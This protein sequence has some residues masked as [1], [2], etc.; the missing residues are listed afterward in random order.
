MKRAVKVETPATQPFPK[1]VM[2]NAES[3]GTDKISDEQ[4]QEWL[5]T[6]D[7]KNFL[8]SLQ[9]GVK[10]PNIKET[11]QEDEYT[12][13]VVEDKESDSSFWSIMILIVACGLCIFLSSLG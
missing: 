5:K 13:E 4:L 6:T 3:T 11:P 1:P 2:S 10:E 12:G 8:E 7:G 9:D